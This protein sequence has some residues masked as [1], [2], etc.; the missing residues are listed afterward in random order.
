MR[1]GVRRVQRIYLSLL[2]LNTLAASFIWGINTL[3]LLDAGLSNTEAFAAN[4]FFT[5]GMVV[6]E[7]PTGVIADLRGRRTSYLLGVITLSLSTLIYL[8]MWETS[9]PFWGWAVSSV[10]LGLG[11][12]FF[13]G[14][15]EAWLVDALTAAGYD[16]ELDVVFGKG[17]IAEDVAMLAGSVGGGFL[18]QVTNLGVPYML[19]AAVL[20]VTFVIA[21]IAMRDEGFTPSRGE[22][23]LGQVRA[24]LADSIT[25]GLRNP[26]VRWVMLSAPLMSGVMIYGFYAAQPYL[27]EL[28]GDTG[29]YG[30]AGL[31]AAIFAGAQM[32]GGALVSRIGKAFPTRTSVL[33]LASATGAFALIVA[34]AVRSFW[35][36]I[37][38]LVLWSFVLAAMTPVRQ[39]YVNGLIPSS[40]RATVLSF[41]SLMGSA[42]GVVVQPGLGR[43]ADTSSYGASFVVG[44]VL[45]AAAVPLMLLAARENASSDRIREAPTAEEG[46]TAGDTTAS[47]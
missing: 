27:L 23:P 39:A 34:G 19:R 4:A 37:A 12:T 29:A 32:A 47:P 16:G 45:H 3:F 9:A 43:V 2:F 5:V 25:F 44:G 35:L 15:V 14:A 31:A 33:I 7:V 11:F 26:P 30:I 21:F 46:T 28:Y 41:D 13:S 24:I 38:M 8:L 22:R 1:S 6:F 17:Q 10:L 36:T 42:G 20:G 40:R 18:A